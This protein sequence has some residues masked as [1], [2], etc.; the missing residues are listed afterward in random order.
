MRRIFFGSLIC[1]IALLC[2]A[3]AQTAA[4]PNAVIGD[5]YMVEAPAFGAKDAPHPHSIDLRFRMS[6]GTLKGAIL[7][8]IDHS[9]SPLAMSQFD[10][11]TLRFQ[12]VADTGKSQAEM[13]VMVMPWNGLRFQGSWTKGTVEMAGPKFKL[14]RS[15]P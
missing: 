10:G 15:T 13:P 6:E 5:W 8:K 9:E 2:G 7:S 1:S 12:Q 3:S 4:A 11:A 14:V